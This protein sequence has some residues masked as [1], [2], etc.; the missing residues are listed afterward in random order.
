MLGPLHDQKVGA[1][2][3]AHWLKAVAALPSRGQQ[4]SPQHSNTT[5]CNCS[6]RGSDA[7]ILASSSTRQTHDAQKCIE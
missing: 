7:L 5:A 2:K 6:P 1:G 4:S 3:I